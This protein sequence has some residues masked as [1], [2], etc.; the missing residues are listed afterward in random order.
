MTVPDF[1]RGLVVWLGFAIAASVS[2]WSPEFQ[3]NRSSEPIGF[4]EAP[5]LSEVWGHCLDL[6]QFHHTRLVIVL[7]DMIYL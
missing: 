1:K 6:I 4:R 5:D 3:T 7:F 2:P